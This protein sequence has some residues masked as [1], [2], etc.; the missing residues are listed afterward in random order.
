VSGEALCLADGVHV[1]VHE[2]TAWARRVLDPCA[3]TDDATE[4]DLSLPGELLPG[5]Y[6]DWVLLERERLRQPRMHALEALADKYA[7][8]GRYGEA[9]Q[10]AF[11]AARAEPL[12]ESAHRTVIRIH[13][14]EGNV[15]EA[16]REYESFR[17]LLA[18]EMSVAPTPLMLELM[19]SFPRCHRRLGVSPLWP[20]GRGTG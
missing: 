12:R 14:A 19:G 15:A 18:T 1:D 3:T 13:L 20:S 16:V 17:A 2:L 9:A 10:A 7:G 8:A 4:G 11:A 6:D 5:W